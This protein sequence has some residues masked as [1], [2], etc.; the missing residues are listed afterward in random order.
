MID[1]K[2]ILQK[3][4]S[5]SG[6][7]ELIGYSYENGKISLDIKL[8]EDDILNIQFETEILYAKNIE[9]RSPFNVGYF[10]CIKLSDV[11]KIENNHYSFSGGFVDIMKAQRKK[12]NL[13][14]GLPISNY[15]HLITFCN[16]SINLAFI[17]NE[18]NNY[19]FE[20][21]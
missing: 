7:S 21:Y 5:K 1:F 17:V 3:K 12:I 19:K 14:F 10:E 9:L 15:T 18:N 13:A 6:D 2:N 4:F 20:S 11:L 16:S 8:E